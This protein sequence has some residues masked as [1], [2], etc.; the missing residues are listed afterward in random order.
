M[1]FH[2]IFEGLQFNNT[3]V[4]LNL[5]RTGIA[6]I[7]P[8]TAKS[9]TRMLQVNKSL[10]HLDLSSTDFLTANGIFQYSFQGL[11]HNTTLLHLILR[12]RDISYN[13]AAC[14]AQA[15]KSNLSLQALSIA[16]CR[17]EGIHL[18]L[19]ALNFN[20]TLKH[21]YVTQGMEQLSSDFHK[22]NIKEERLLPPIDVVPGSRSA[23]VVES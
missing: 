19:D 9:L 8:L 14:I 22:I 1:I 16:R 3:L 6:A 4:K 23:K 17:I 12:Y 13:D 18:I 20:T 2:C 21:L 7:D 11:K 10:I 5:N 15:L